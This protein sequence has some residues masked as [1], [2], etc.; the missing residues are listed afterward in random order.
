MGE[1]PERRKQLQIH[2]DCTTKY[3]ALHRFMKM[4]KENEFMAA[5]CLAD[6]LA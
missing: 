4:R 5:S 3:V 1:W 6:L 2:S